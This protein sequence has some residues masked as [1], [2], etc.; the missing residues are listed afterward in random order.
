MIPPAMAPPLPQRLRRTLGRTPG[1]SR[2][3]KS[4]LL[5]AAFIAIALGA[6]RFSR[7]PDLSHVDVAILSGSPQG[8]YYAIVSKAA[9]EAKR[10]SLERTWGRPSGESR[11][12]QHAPAILPRLRR[13]RFWRTG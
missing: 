3:V 1:P 7:E 6:T 8:N 4:L 11:T 9:D 10:L 12:V 2:T 5:S 13:S